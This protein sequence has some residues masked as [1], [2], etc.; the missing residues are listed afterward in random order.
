M[1]LVLVV[2]LVV[3][4]A[5]LASLFARKQGYSHNQ[6]IVLSAIAVGLLISSM[7]PGVS[8]GKAIVVVTG[9]LTLVASVIYL[10]KSG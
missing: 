2:V 1:S 4:L 9:I 8:A 3:G 7:L 10:R 6:R 5:F